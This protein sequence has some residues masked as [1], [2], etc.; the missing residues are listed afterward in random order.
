MDK[1]L[2]ELRGRTFP[3]GSKITSLMRKVDAELLGGYGAELRCA[4]I[5]KCSFVQKQEFKI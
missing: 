3:L 1:Q 2:L 5:C 4:M